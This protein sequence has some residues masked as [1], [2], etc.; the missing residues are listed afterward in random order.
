MVVTSEADSGSNGLDKAQET[1]W[2]HL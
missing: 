1:F 2:P